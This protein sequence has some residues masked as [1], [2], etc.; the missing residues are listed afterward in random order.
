MFLL[1]TSIRGLIRTKKKKLK[2]PEYK[3]LLFMS[4]LQFKLF[5][6]RSPRLGRHILTSSLQIRLPFIS[7]KKAPYNSLLG[8]SSIHITCH[9]IVTLLMVKGFNINNH[10]RQ[11]D[12]YQ[13]HTRQ[14]WTQSH[15]NSRDFLQLQ[16]L[17]PRE[18]QKA[19]SEL[20][21]PD[22]SL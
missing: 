9:P 4:Q 15:L 14:A 5:H 2:F 10:S 18:P 3:S 17:W 8:K 19:N 16:I 21:I 13:D 20:T 1:A 12:I 7:I 6:S 22:Y 11:T